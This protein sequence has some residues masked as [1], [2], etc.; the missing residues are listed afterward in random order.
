M[1]RK[2]GV[3]ESNK[4]NKEKSILIIHYIKVWHFNGFSGAN[5]RRLDHFIT[6]V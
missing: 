1:M 2:C 5:I 6:P 3:D 4:R